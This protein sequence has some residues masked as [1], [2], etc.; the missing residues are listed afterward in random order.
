MSNGISP[1]LP[2]RRDKADGYELNKTLK[3]KKL[4]KIL[5]DAFKNE[6]KCVISIDHIINILDLENTEELMRKFKDEINFLQED[7]TIESDIDIDSDFD[8]DDNEEFKPVEN[9][10]Y[11]DKTNKTLSNHGLFVY[12]ANINKNF[13]NSA[14]HLRK[15]RNFQNN[16]AKA[17]YQGAQKIRNLLI[18]LSNDK[19][20]G[21]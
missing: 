16:I 1:K 20:W 19:I 3:N 8:S 14:T 21:Y 6:N 18:E 7:N 4:C 2:L 13:V 10:V 11:Y 5:F 17:A 12:L 15:V 9:K